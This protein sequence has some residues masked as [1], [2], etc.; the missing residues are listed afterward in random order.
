VDQELLICQQKNTTKPCKSPLIPLPVIAQPWRRLAFDIVGPLPKTKDGYRYV[1]TCMDYSSRYPEA[2]PLKRVDAETVADGILSVFTRFGIPEEVLTDNGTVFV[3]NLTQH[4]LKVLGVKHIHIS[5]Y[6]PQTNGMLERWHRVFKTIV[7]KLTDEKRWKQVLPLALFASRDSPHASTGL[8]P[9]EILFGWD[10]RGPNSILRELWTTPKRAPANVLRYLEKLRSTLDLTT[11]VAAT[12]D[13]KAKAKSKAQYD[14]ATREDRLEVGDE[15]LILHP[16]GPTG[17]KGCWTGPY[18]IEEILSPVSYRIA[19]PG[20]KGAVMHRNHLKRFIRTEMVNTVVIADGQLD[21][22]GQLEIPSLPGME[23]DLSAPPEGVYQD[24]LPEQKKQLNKLLAQYATTFSD[25]PGHTDLLE[26]DIDTG[27]SKPRNKHPYRIPKRWKQKLVAEIQVLLK[28]EVIRPSK[29]PW[30]SPVV[31]VAKPGDLLR[32]CIDYRDLNSITEPDSYP[33]P[34]IEEIIERVAPAKFIS[35][36]DLAKGYYQVP[37]A[38]DVMKKTAFITPSGKFEF[39]KMPFG[40]RNAPSAFQRLMDMVLDGLDSSKAYIDDVVVFSDTWEQHLEDLKTTLERLKK[41]GLTVKRRKC[42]W[43]C[44]L[45]SFLGHHIGQGQVRPQETKIQAI[46]NYK[47]PQSKKDLRAFIGLVGYYRRFIPSFSHRAANLTDCTGSKRPDQ[48]VWTDELEREFQDL[49][50][51]LT[52]SSV[53]TAY[54]PELPLSLHTDASDR[55]IGATLSQTVHGEE[56]PIAFFSKKMLGRETRYS[57]TEK[58]CL[59]IVR[60]VKHFEAYLLGVQFELVT[61]HKAL[62]ALN[63]TVGGGARLVRWALALQPFTFTIVH[64]QASLHADADGL[65]R[66]SWTQDHSIQGDDEPDLAL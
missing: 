61:D 36:L 15:V 24:L 12:A 34:L 63:K 53:L 46:L 25:I 7:S 54:N 21:R 37:L 50:T 42:V 64:R 56:K 1:L 28:T 16:D 32:M 5:P 19:T 6:H 13:A 18:L 35:T 39:T 20:K 3:G 9:F 44:A 33:M 59:A 17:L 62:L 51:A 30:A 57:T 48:L 31:C 55:G 26:L 29:S 38:R 22:T 2:I 66:Q 27:Q 11:S 8:T 40:L 43:G 41:A 52:H 47:R 4:L 60:A 45:V 58:E 65:S 10:V 49:R 14:K 23:E